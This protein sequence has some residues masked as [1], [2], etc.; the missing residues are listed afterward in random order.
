MPEQDTFTDDAVLDRNTL[1]TH[2]ED[3]KWAPSKVAEKFNVTEDD[4]RRAINV[5]DINYRPHATAASTT[6]PA[7]TLVEMDPDDLDTSGGES[8]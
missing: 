6:G 5:H 2:I 7:K 1:A 4:V 3:W 8:A